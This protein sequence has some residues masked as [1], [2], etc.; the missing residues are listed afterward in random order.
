[1][2]RG[3]IGELQVNGS[4]CADRHEYCCQKEMAKPGSDLNNVCLFTFCSGELRVVEHFS[5]ASFAGCANGADAAD[6]LKLKLLG[7]L[8][9]AGDWMICIPA[10]SSS[11]FSVSL[12]SCLPRASIRVNFGGL[13]EVLDTLEAALVWVGRALS[14]TYQLRTTSFGGCVRMW[15]LE[16]VDASAG[17][18]VLE[19]GRGLPFRAFRHVAV[20]VKRNDLCLIRSA[21]GKDEPPRS[22]GS[23]APSSPDNSIAESGSGYHP[24]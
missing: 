17:V 2:E 7:S 6:V 5:L 3:S 21:A 24:F 16:P 22:A 10:I 9:A 14:V 11:G 23:R 4:S 18:D 12:R 15:R 8:P 1:M 19:A 20:S 13:E